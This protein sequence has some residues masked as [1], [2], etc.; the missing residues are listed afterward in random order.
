MP[1]GLPGL[2]LVPN[3]TLSM[4]QIDL[5]DVTVA[6]TATTT[7]TSDPITG[8]PPQEIAPY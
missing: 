7:F 2:L 4:P 8:L 6:P 3:S 1:A 5:Y